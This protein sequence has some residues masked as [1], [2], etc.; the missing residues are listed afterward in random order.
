MHCDISFRSI[1]DYVLTAPQHGIT[2]EDE[3]IL[4][5]KGTL[6]GDIDGIMVWW[7]DVALSSRN[8]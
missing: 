4:V 3:R 8:G 2:N 5:W 1:A 7:M 6:T